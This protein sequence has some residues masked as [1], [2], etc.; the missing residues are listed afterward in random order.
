MGKRD[1]PRDIRASGTSPAIYAGWPACPER[2]S[3]GAGLS[4]GPGHPKE[5]DARIRLLLHESNLCSRVAMGIKRSGALPVHATS[6][7][8]WVETDALPSET[9]HAGPLHRHEGE[10]VRSA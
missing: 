4:L 3:G 8:C 2:C 7:Q 5:V 10:A 6:P 9:D 1:Q